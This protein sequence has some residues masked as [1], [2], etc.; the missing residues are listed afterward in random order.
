MMVLPFGLLMAL[1]AQRLQIVEVERELREIL[2]RLFVVDLSR[3]VWRPG[4]VAQTCLAN[5]M[6]S[7]QRGP[8]E[9]APCCRVVKAL[10]LKCHILIPFSGYNAF[11]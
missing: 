9:P 11:A 4:S 3:R 2:Q 6:V 7:A 10:L 8:A 5:I 1:P